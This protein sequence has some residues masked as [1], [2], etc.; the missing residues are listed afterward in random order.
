MTRTDVT[1]IVGGGV[2]G[3]VLA[4]RLALA[5]RRVTILEA[6]DRLG[7][8]LARQRIAG[9]E[10]DAA[11]ESFGTRGGGVRALVDELG[12]AADVVSPA[13]SPAWVQRARGGAVPL[14]VAGLLGIPADPRAADVVRAVG[15]RGALRA[16]LDELLPSSV[17]SDATTVGDLVAARMGRAVLDTLVAPVARGVYSRE[18]RELPLDVAAPL[19]RAALREHGS[20]AAAVRSL[21]T[22]APAGS[23]V[24]GLR[25]GMFR[26]A[27]ALAAECARLGVVVE[28]GVRVDDAPP[29]AVWAASRPGAPAGREVMLVTLVL[30]AAGLDGA[31]RG[32]GVLVAPGAGVAARALTHLTAKWRWIADALPGRHVL[33][34]SYDTPPADPVATALADAAALFAIPLPQAVDATVS[35]WSRAAPDP[36]DGRQV[37]EPV[38]GVGLASVIPHAEA[39]A[40][41]LLDDSPLHVGRGRMES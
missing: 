35:T 37:G 3:L 10:L 14:P 19:L 40:A 29:G 15:R 9:V 41:T 18:A 25:G 32:S 34:L 27:D 6:S 12:L 5:G 4:R 22:S 31:P 13:P 17:G 33:R 36:R 11:A 1:T 7:G 30:E 38:A 26:L 8:Q 21:R 39:L 2:A 20:L 24:A 28:T 23:L 16:Q